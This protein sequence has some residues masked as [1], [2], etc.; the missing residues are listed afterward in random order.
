MH[1]LL[2]NQYLAQTSTETGPGAGFII[3]AILAVIALYLL[4][5]YVMYKTAI[6]CGAEN[7]WYQ[8]V[9]ILN[10]YGMVVE[11]AQLE[12]WYILLMFV[13]L[14]NVVVSFYVMW[15]IV[16][17]AGFPGWT[18]LLLLIPFVGFFMPFYWAF[19]P[20]TVLRG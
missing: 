10:L 5:S 2:T 19:A 20:Q 8:F 14:V 9:P 4:Y 11:M 15:R 6:R 1:E 7:P 3:L 13:P 12:W 16:E 18:V 17:N